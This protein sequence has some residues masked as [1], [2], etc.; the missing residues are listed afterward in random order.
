MKDENLERWQQLCAEAATGHDPDRLM[1]L[2]AEI[3]RMLD[4]KERR[5]KPQ[6]ETKVQGAGNA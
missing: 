6:H 2:I 5:L 1:K 4:E 3:N